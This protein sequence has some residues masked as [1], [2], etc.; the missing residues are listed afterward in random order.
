MEFVFSRQ[1][2]GE[3]K[4]VL[5]DWAGTTLDYGCYAPAVVF[6]DV[7]EKHGVP[8]TIQEARVPMGAHKREH[9]RQI[10]QIEAVAE[11]WEAKHGCQPTS[12][13]VE[14]MFQD[15]VP[16]QLKVLDHIIIGNNQYFSFADRGL[17]EDYEFL[18]QDLKRRI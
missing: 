1:Y 17:I 3:L 9:I 6:V 4:A 8:I 14:S 15:F 11:R 2:R 5:L 16:M 12:E 18:F 10:S 13:D 7:Y